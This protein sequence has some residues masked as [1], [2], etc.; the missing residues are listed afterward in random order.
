MRRGFA[1]IFMVMIAVV[2]LFIWATSQHF[3]TSSVRKRV[4][5]A[6]SERAARLMA[7]S[8]T[9]QVTKLFPL[10]LRLQSQGDNPL[11]GSGEV[12][13]RSF[14]EWGFGGPL[15]VPVTL[16]WMSASMKNVPIETRASEVTL[17][18]PEAFRGPPQLGRSLEGFPSARQTLCSHY[19]SFVEEESGHGHAPDSPEFLGHRQLRFPGWRPLELEGIVLFETDTRAATRGVPLT[20]HATLVRQYRLITSPCPG[21]GEETPPLDLVVHPIELGRSVTTKRGAL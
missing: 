19:Q 15:T 17:S 3:V 18:P 6:E 10:L 11:L 1:A 13:R 16:P 21:V 9:D 7:L 20:V 5:I 14:S 2:L 12:F 4:R 8:T